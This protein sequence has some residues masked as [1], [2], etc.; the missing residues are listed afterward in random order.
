MYHL[1]DL[2]KGIGVD[3]KLERRRRELRV[4]L[5]GGFVLI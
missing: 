4:R 1:Q 3:S 5:K 2:C